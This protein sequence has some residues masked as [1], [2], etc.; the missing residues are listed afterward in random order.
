MLG[1]CSVKNR[2]DKF[3]ENLGI[4]YSRKVEL[5]DSGTYFEL[6]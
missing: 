6:A 4:V 2:L 5:H 3:W 1:V